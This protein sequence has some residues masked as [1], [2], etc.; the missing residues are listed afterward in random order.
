MKPYDL[1]PIMGPDS[2]AFGHGSYRRSGQ[3]RGKVEW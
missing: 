2:N 1:K 3:V